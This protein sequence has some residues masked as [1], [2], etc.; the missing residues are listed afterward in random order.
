[1]FDWSDQSIHWLETK[2]DIQ[3][4]ILNKANSSTTM[5]LVAN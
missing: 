2:A 1:M 3:F 5:E 4:C